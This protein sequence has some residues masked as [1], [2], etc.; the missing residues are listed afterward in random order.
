MG[1]VHLVS[2]RFGVQNPDLYLTQQIPFVRVTPTG[3]WGQVNSSYRDINASD[4]TEPW[5][6]PPDLCYDKDTMTKWVLLFVDALFSLHNL[7]I[8]PTIDTH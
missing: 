1:F 4:Y 7:M 8:L 3:T 6:C 2:E 5:G